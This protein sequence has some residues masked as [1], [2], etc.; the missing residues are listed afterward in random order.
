[1]LD[2]SLRE[3]GSTLRVTARLI[4]A[5]GGFIVWSQSY[6]RPQDD[7]PMIRDDIVS[8]VVEALQLQGP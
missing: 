7:L 3:S 4:R 5:D 2:G 8:H 1:M 6:E